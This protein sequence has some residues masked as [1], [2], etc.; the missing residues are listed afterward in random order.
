MRDLN[1]VL[2]SEIF[3]HSDG[4]LRASHLLLGCTPRCTT[5]Q[6]FGQALLVDS[7][8]LSYIDVW[9]PNLFPFCLTVGKARELGP[10][11]IRAESLELIRKTL[12][13]LVSQNCAVHRPVEKPPAQVPG[14]PTEQATE[15][16]HS[17]E[18]ETDRGEAE[19]VSRQTLTIVCFLLST[20]SITQQQ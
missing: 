19:M 7:P 20:R 12:A 4:Q 5:W 8:L 6:P 1:F 11:L 2:R 17:S 14:G 18:A 16:V 15:S 9:H 10:C 3:V 13:K